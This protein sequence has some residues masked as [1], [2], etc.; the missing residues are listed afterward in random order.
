M[1][2]KENSNNDK[3][4]ALKIKMYIYPKARLSMT[5][6]EATNVNIIV[7]R[8]I[9]ALIQGSK[10]RFIV[11]FPCN[12]LD[13]YTKCQIYIVYNIYI[14]KYTNYNFCFESS[15]LLIPWLI[16]IPIEIGDLFIR[17]DIPFSEQA[18]MRWFINNYCSHLTISFFLFFIVYQSTVPILFWCGIYSTYIY[19]KD[20]LVNNFSYC[21]LCN[22]K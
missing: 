3:F 6:S 11:V 18:K 10:L 5:S 12:R 8:L 9:I 20:I 14:N 1:N 21:N 15:Y 19:R 7:L 13:C 16:H 2:L 22:L 17:F 4:R